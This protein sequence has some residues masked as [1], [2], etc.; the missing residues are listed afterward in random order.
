MTRG[1][2]RRVVRLAAAAVPA[3]QRSRWRNEWLAEVDYSWRRPANLGRRWHLTARA[4]HSLG[5]AL[6]LRKE[7]LTMNGLKLDLSLA[8]RAL[9]RQPGFAAIAVLTLALGVGANVSILGVIRGTLLADMPFGHP[10]ALMHVWETLPSQGVQENTPAPATVDVWRERSGLAESFA[11]YTS[12]VVNVT[13]DGD[14]ERLRALRASAALL[15]TLELTPA[16]GRN[17]TSDEDRFGG[18]R[19]VL[20]GHDF[21]TRRYH[22]DPSIVG[23]QIR[24]DGESTTVVGVL[25]PGVQMALANVDVWVPLALKP[26]ES[27]QSRM[28]WVVARA[29]PGVTPAALQQELDAGMHREGPGQMPDGIGVYVASMDQQLRGRVRPDLLLV[30]GVSAVVLLMACGNVAMMLFVRGL[31]RRQ[32]LAIRTAVGADRWRLARLLLAESVVLGAAGGVAGYLTGAAS[33]RIIGALLPTSLR[34]TIVVQRDAGLFAAALGLALVAATI[35]ALAPMFG[36]TLA[37]SQVRGADTLERGRAA[38]L[39]GG[40]VSAQMALAVLLLSA[41]ALLGRTFATIVLAPTGFDT[42]GVL[43]AQV[44]RADTDDAR[45]TAFYA[46]LLDRLN[47][48]PGV[49]GAALINGLP[50]RFSGG[51]SGFL[52]DGATQPVAG[53]HRI[54]SPGYFGVMGIPLRAGRDFSGGDRAGSAPV[55]VVSE[56]FARAAWP[57]DAAVGQ[58]LRWGAD[59][60]TFEVAGVVG[61]V[62]LLRGD[63]AAPHV[64]FTFQQVQYPFY[65]PSDVAIRTT[66]APGTFAPALRAIVQAIDADQPVANVLTMSELAARSVGARRFTLSL[67][68]AFAALALALSAIGLYGMQSFGVQR[69]RREFGLR[70]ALGATS[71][72]LRLAVLAQGLRLTAFGGAIGIALTYGAA[73]VFRASVPGLAMLDAWAVAAAFV[74]LVAVAALASDIPARRASKVDP[75]RALAD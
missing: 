36:G 23:R 21:W 55:V 38:W 67:M 59:S 48:A 20:L 37:V 7:T 24:L 29:K 40:L 73:R 52:P 22:R 74:V 68:T 5:H 34:G 33:L 64:Y 44:P 72:R 26:T 27:R 14:P 69:R 46:D 42:S 56:S 71:A 39:R 62:H 43:T 3:R 11:P 57:N 58:R 66:G 4:A 19:A 15:S 25:P 54:V 63:A 31:S 30:F 50:L 65:M 17:F 18:P 13:G 16:I 12:A 6:W 53:R 1:T 32:E 2:C 60:Q 28:L 45:R 75:M 9:R 8:A 47:A 51:G 35:A 61:D 10:E 41:T 49:T 70:V